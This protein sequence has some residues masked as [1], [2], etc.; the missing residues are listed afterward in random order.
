MEGMKLNNK[1]GMHARFKNA[2]SIEELIRFE[3]EFDMP[4]LDISNPLKKEEIKI[5][6]YS[7][8]KANKD[9]AT[10]LF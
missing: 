10:G 4:A 9:S 3:N 5:S 1:I 7:S 2:A 6:Y 8:N